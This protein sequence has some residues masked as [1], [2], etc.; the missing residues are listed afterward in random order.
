MARRMRQ[1]HEHLPSAAFALAPAIPDDRLAA[2]EP[3]LRP[4]PV[5]HKLGRRCLGRE[6]RSS[7]SQPSMIP[8]NR[9]SSGRFTRAVRRSPGSTENARIL[10]TPSR[11]MVKCRAACR[12]LMPA[13]WPVTPRPRHRRR[14][15]V[16]SSSVPTAM[17]RRRRGSRRPV[18]RLRCDRETA[19]LNTIRAGLGIGAP[20]RRSA[21]GIAPLTGRRTVSDE[22]AGDPVRRAR[23]SAAPPAR[24]PRRPCP[25][26]GR[27]SPRRPPR[28]GRPGRT[29]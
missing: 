29:G 11:E 17:R 22:P 12:W 6:R 7:S 9:S 1:R 25:R 26:R 23:R 14:R 5:E 24:R 20:R 2:G 19:Q 3:M 15:P 21:P 13:I 18:D 10:R 4:Q 16:M 8:V 27:R 28:A